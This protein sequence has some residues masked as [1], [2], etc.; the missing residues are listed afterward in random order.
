MLGVKNDVLKQLLEPKVLETITSGKQKILDLG[1][2]S[3]RI[4][5][6]LKKSATESVMTMTA[7]SV[8]GPNLVV[9]DLKSQVAGK[10]QGDIQTLLQSYPGVKDV[11]I[12]YA[13]FWVFTT[14]KKPTKIQ[15]TIDGGN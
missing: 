8:I 6:K 5:A 12:T 11:T 4:S 13:P 7:T 10:K 14:P 2:N 3:A 15:I 9:D 1:L